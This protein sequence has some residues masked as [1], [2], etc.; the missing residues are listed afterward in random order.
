M[1]KSRWVQISFIAVV[2]FAVPLVYSATLSGT[3]YDI[4]LSKISP[5]RVEINTTPKQVVIARDGTYSLSLPPGFYS[6][7]AFYSK[8]GAPA[9]FY[10]ENISILREGDFTVDLVLFPSFPDEDLFETIAVNPEEEIQDVKNIGWLWLIPV[11]VIILIEFLIWSKRRN[12]FKKNLE[13]DSKQG[14]LGKSSLREAA[15]NKEENLNAGDGLLQ[16]VLSIIQ[17]EGGRTTQKEIRK[18]IPLSE[19]KV[20]LILTELEHEGKIK[21]IKKG[22]G[23]VVVLGK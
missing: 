1:K 20:S 2:L 9:A 15:N 6:L 5:V 7:K 16:Q 4:G 3:T 11:I 10:Q 22:R 13:E 23:N 17:K 19:A 8:D 18:H 21:K 14:N 12:G